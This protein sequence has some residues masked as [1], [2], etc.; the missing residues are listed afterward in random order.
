MSTKLFHKINTHLF[1]I[2]EFL[3]FWLNFLFVGYFTWIVKLVLELSNRLDIRMV[4]D[5]TFQT[6]VINLNFLNSDSRARKTDIRINSKSIQGLRIL[7]D[8]ILSN[9]IHLKLQFFTEKVFSSWVT[10]NL[11]PNWSWNFFLHKSGKI[12]VIYVLKHYSYTVVCYKVGFFA[13]FPN[14][15]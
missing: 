5:F 1:N 14:I 6:V 15:L 9:N 4:D 10:I 8:T 7:S 2:C 12:S 3:L 11:S 13:I